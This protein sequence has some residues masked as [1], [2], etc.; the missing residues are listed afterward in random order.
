MN[1]ED[2]TALQFLV[3]DHEAMARICNEQLSRYGDNLSVAAQAALHNM[4]IVHKARAEEIKAQ[5]AED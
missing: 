1:T 2:Q 4:R 5:L 3:E